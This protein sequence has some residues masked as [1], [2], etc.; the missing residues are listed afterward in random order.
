M[1][2]IAIV[3]GGFDSVTLLH[4]LVKTE[5]RRPAVMTFRYGQRHDKELACAEYQVRLL[6]CGDHR[7]VD[8]SPM[9]DLWQRSS[10]IDRGM[11]IPDAAEVDTETQPSSYVPNRNMIFLALAVA[12]AE[13]LG[14]SEVFYGA[15]K[16]DLYGYWDTTDSFVQAL[17]AVY[18]QASSPVRIRT[19]FVTMSKADILRL[20]LDLGVDYSRT[21]S[22]YQGETRACGRCPT[23]IERLHAFAALGLADPIA[24]ELEARPE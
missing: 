21:W 4:H 7:M 14:V 23:C 2:C 11:A 20:G 5:Q 22:C 15:Q 8:I 17:N 6:S 24:Y 13:T 12:Y 16:H 9:A 3:S 19:P 1:D 10:L 18:G